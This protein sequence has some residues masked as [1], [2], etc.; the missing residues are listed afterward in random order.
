M[1]GVNNRY[2]AVQD[3]LGRVEQLKQLQSRGI[4]GWLLNYHYVMAL[5]LD[6]NSQKWVG[7]LGIVFVVLFCG[8]I[9]AEEWDTGTIELLRGTKKGHTRLRYTS[10]DC[11]SIHCM[12][13]FDL[14]TYYFKF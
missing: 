1:N 9:Y 13:V 11:T 5:F 3:V 10:A 8:G 6:E 2:T 12:P 7:L 14:G 4:T